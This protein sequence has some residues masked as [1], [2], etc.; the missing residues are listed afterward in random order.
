M[1]NAANAASPEGATSWP[2]DTTV[3][4]RRRDLSAVISTGFAFVRRHARS[5]FRPLLFASLPFM[6]MGSLF[7]SSF[8]H[9]VSEGDRAGTPWT[10]FAAYFSFILAYIVGCALV[11]EYVRFVLVNQ[12]AR[13]KANDLWVV[14]R[15]HVWLYLGVSVLTAIMTSVASMIFF[16]PG[17]FMTIVFQ[18]SYPLH[19][20]E[21]A[22][23]GDCIGRSF[24]LIWGYWWL[25]FIL[26]VA[27][28]GMLLLMMSA[29][30]IP[31]WV[32]TSFLSMSGIDVEGDPES[33]S[34]RLRLIATIGSLFTACT[35]ILLMPFLQVPMIFQVLSTTEAK[36]APGLLKEVRH[37]DLDSAP[38]S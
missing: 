20:I 17:V 2:R 31:A 36:E 32:I 18:F 37:F 11:C 33:T 1:S 29:I 12:G 21:R 22:S 35:Y 9:T 3:F 14:L 15:R 28:A 8:F 5:L 7:T 26:V 38:R 34:L 25:T 19:A 13:P 4:H 30:D 10:F 16:L 23:V 6:V 27:L 24:S